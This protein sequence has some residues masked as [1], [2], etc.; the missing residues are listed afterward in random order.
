MKR[1]MIIPSAGLGS[2]LQS[3]TPKVILHVNGKS[4]IE[5][6]FSLYQHEIDLFF[7]VLHPSFQAE[8]SEFCSRFS[9]PIHFVTQDSPT[10]MLDAVLQPWEQIKLQNPD[11]IWITW[12]DQ[13]G[14]HPRTVRKL[15]E[16]ARKKPDLLFPTILRKDPYI[17]MVRNAD[18][19]IIDVLHRREGDSLPESGENDLGLFCLS[20]Q[21][22]LES[23]RSYAKE[24]TR[25]AVTGEKNFLPFISWLSSH[26]ALVQSFPAREE[27]ESIGINTPEDLQQMEQYL[28]NRSQTLSVVIPAYNEERFIGQLLE[29]VLTVDLSALKVDKEVLVIDDHSKDRTAEIARSFA[30]VQVL[31][32]P[33]NSGKGEAVKTGIAAATGD[34]LIIQDADLEYE[35]NDYL[36]MLK[37]MLSGAADVVYGSR[38]MKSGKYTNQ[39]WTAFLGGRS[40]SLIGWLFTGTY[41]TDTVTAL[42]LFRAETIKSMDLKT[43]G[44]EL[45]HEITSKVLAQGLTI[46]EISINYFPRTK[47]EGKKIGFRDWVKA[48][49]TFYRY[50]NWA[51]ATVK[52]QES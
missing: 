44:F 29:K 16:L 2:R 15:A 35:P 27:M 14:V 40:L 11:Q 30:S 37:L 9:F 36:E 46:R 39:S 13:I 10:G 3:K 17:H 19:K 25:S 43:T 41:L 8:V 4:M 18:G 28:K 24:A 51:K 7:V 1:F 38:Y 48:V 26:D 49:K 6:L 20:R 21:T 23:L 33:K 52:R 22:Y 34:F 12:C 5:H 47:A 50:G 31:T 45:D 42:K 32:L